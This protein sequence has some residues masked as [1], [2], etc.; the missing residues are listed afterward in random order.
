MID[1][2]ARIEQG[3]AIKE[4]A[5][6]RGISAKALRRHLSLLSLLEE[7]RRLVERDDLSIRNWPIRDAI[8]VGA[9]Q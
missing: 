2:R 9:I 5:S 1:V 3:E 4:I 6:E 8:T 7:K